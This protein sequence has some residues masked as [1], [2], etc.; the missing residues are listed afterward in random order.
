MLEILI[1]VK[2]KITT[3]VT[4]RKV[5]MLSHP[6]N[7]SE[8]VGFFPESGGGHRTKG[9]CKKSYER[10][11]LISIITVVFNG[12]KYL[13]E[14]ILSVLNQTY[15]NVEYII[16][17]G[18]STDGTL[19]IIKKYDD[20]IDYWASKKD[21]G[22]YDAMNKG[23]NASNGNIIGIVNSDDFLYL[24]TLEKIAQYFIDDID[25]M[26]TYGNVN[27]VDENGEFFFTAKSLGTS[28]FKYQIFRHMPFLHPTMFI[29]KEVY[30]QI[31][32][33]DPSYKVSADY[34]FSLRLIENRFKGIELSFTT[35]V[36][37]LGGQSGGI[38]TYNEDLMISLKHKTNPLIAY[39][40]ILVLLTKM[41][42]R[43]T[44]RKFLKIY[45]NFIN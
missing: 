6:E 7:K 35:G 10:K 40:N 27:I 26:Y 31:G 23:I 8:T 18:G 37:R 32:C 2:K 13:E 29:R 38:S 30:N 44:Y 12:E 41:K 14:T 42:I 33:Y 19:D 17:D 25:L 39:F 20:K 4:P 24:G 43:I 3:F 45:E 11:P 21:S 28:S 5:E 9:Y 34:D 36:F 22:I 1:C 15:D 16:I